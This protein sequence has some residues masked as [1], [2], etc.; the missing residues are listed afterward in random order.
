MGRGERDG[1]DHGAGWSISR[2]M[3]GSRSAT[4]EGN[5]AKTR[6]AVRSQD[7]RKRMQSD[8]SNGSCVY[9]TKE[10]YLEDL[11]STKQANANSQLYTV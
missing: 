10:E 3:S 7:G 6:Y 9:R 5:G 11:K 2:F 4:F 8:F 1:I